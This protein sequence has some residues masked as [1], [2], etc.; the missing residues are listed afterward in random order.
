MWFSKIKEPVL[1]YNHCSQKLKHQ[2]TT[3]KNCQ[4]F[5]GFEI[6]WTSTSLVLTIFSKVGELLKKDT[7]KAY[8]EHANHKLDIKCLRIS[9]NHD[10]TSNDKAKGKCRWLINRWNLMMDDF[11][12]WLWM[13]KLMVMNHFHS[14]CMKRNF[15]VYASLYEQ[16]ITSSSCT[17][18]I[19]IVYQ[20]WWMWM[21]SPPL[22]EKEFQTNGLNIV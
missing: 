15:I 22:N 21:T 6:I 20:N 5:T 11:I 9:K 8:N 14:F 10:I 2:I 7:I 19:W 13:K 3:H 1:I 4:F 17:S 12:Q 18:V 16:F